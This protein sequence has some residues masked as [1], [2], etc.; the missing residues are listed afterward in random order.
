MGVDTASDKL[1]MFWTIYCFAWLLFP[2]SCPQLT[3][4]VPRLSRQGGDSVWYDLW[5]H[6]CGEFHKFAHLG[7]S[8]QRRHI[9]ITLASQWRHSG[10]TV[11]SCVL[12]EFVEEGVA[13]RSCTYI[14]IYIYIY[15][16]LYWIVSSVGTCERDFVVKTMTPL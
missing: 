15:I 7:V 6:T 12:Q 16:Y 14:Y 11:A 1:Q 9:G 5:F 2:A 8:S 13:T 4:H 3:V 10:V